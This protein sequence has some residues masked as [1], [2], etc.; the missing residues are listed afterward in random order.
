MCRLHVA[1]CLFASHIHKRFAQ[2][3]TFNYQSVVLIVCTTTLWIGT[4][5]AS[6]NPRN[7]T[8]NDRRTAATQGTK[9]RVS[10]NRAE[11]KVTPGEDVLPHDSISNAGKPRSTAGSF[12][13]NSSAVHTANERSTERYKV[14]SNESIQLS[15]RSSLK[16]F[17]ANEANAG[18]PKSPKVSRP[19]AVA[20]EKKE[21]PAPCKCRFQS[22]VSEELSATDTLRNS[23]MEASSISRTNHFGAFSIADIDASAFLTTSGVS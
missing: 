7:G 15:S 12:R 22:G 19:L 14:T 9:P 11:T 8:H 17:G 1:G 16:P 23:A 2:R 18:I 5:S 10:S 4:M 6:T 3:G 21:K 20:P 13:P